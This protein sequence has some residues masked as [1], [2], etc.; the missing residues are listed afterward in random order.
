MNYVAPLFLLLL[1]RAAPG[2]DPVITKEATQLFERYKTSTDIAATEE[3]M[4]AYGKQMW[5][6]WQAFTTL[7]DQEG[8]LAEQNAILAAL[9]GGLSKRYQA[10]LDKEGPLNDGKNSAAFEAAFTPEENLLLQDAILDGR[11][12]AETMLALQALSEKKGT[13]DQLV[14][15]YKTEQEHLSGLLGQ[16][17]QIKEETE[18]WDQE[19]DEAVLFFEKGFADIEARPTQERIQGKIDWFRGQIDSGNK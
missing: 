10:F 18:K 14:A 4:I 17:T 19:I 13:Y 8:K 3:A 16:L 6:Y 15:Q 11:K 1:E 2:A 7:M 5:P 12:K 9:P